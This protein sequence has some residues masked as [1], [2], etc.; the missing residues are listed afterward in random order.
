MWLLLVRKGVCSSVNHQYTQPTKQSTR[1]PSG[2]IHPI[3]F[4]SGA[5]ALKLKKR[6]QK[7]LNHGANNK[8]YLSMVKPNHTVWFSY[9]KAKTKVVFISPSRF[10]LATLII[11]HRGGRFFEL[12][13]AVK[14]TLRAVELS[15]F[16]Y[17]L[18][19]LKSFHF[20]VHLL[21][22]LNE[23]QISFRK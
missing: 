12:V 22:L 6:R 11:R 15:Q 5:V 16:I 13:V 19:Y 4:S 1:N 7:G 9:D 20:F 14:I 21:L 10:V 23:V 8:V 2:P 17:V 3:I 18:S